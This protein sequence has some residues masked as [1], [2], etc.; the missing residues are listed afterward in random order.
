MDHKSLQTLFAEHVE[1]LQQFGFSVG[2]EADTTGELVFQLPES[3]LTGGLRH[4]K[5][6]LIPSANICTLQII[7]LLLV[8]MAQI[9]SDYTD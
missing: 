8:G 7:N 5:E 2:V 9:N 1:A 4:C 3:L 6:K